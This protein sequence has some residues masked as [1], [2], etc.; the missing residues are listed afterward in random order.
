MQIKFN[1][2]G[3]LLTLPIRQLQQCLI[4]WVCMCAPLT[5]LLGQQRHIPAA[6]PSGL[7]VYHANEI[8]LKSNLPLLLVNGAV[9]T[10]IPS[11]DEKT[12]RFQVSEIRAALPYLKGA[13]MP[14]AEPLSRVYYLRY[15]GP[16]SPPEVAAAFARDP[17][18]AYA[19]PRYHF[20]PTVAPN[21]SAYGSMP[22]F[23][24]I[25]A[26]VAWEFAKGENGNVV[27]AIIDGGTDWNHED[28]LANVWTNPGEIPG[29]GIDD[30]GNGYVDDLHGWNF[31]TNSPDP[32]GQASTPNIARHGTHVAGTAAAV[33]NNATGMT[34]LSWNCKFMA[35]NIANPNVDDLWSY[36]FEGIVYAA[37]N[38]A[39]V[40]SVSGG[41]PFYTEF[42]REVVEFA[43]ANGALVVAAAG[44]DDQN[45]DLAPFYP[46][47]YDHVLSVGAVTGGDDV[48]AGFSNYGLSVDVFAPGTAIFSTTPGDTYQFLQGTSM[49]TPMVAALAGLV[50]TFRPAWS[51]DQVAE[52]IRV[53]CDDIRGFNPG[54]AG[55]IGK[56][57]INAIRALLQPSPSVRIREASF[58]ESGNDGIIHAGDTVMITLDL[59]NYLEN[60]ANLSL[61]LRP[62]DANIGFLQASAA[63]PLLNTGQSTTVQFEV[64]IDPGLAAGYRLPFVLDITDGNTYIDADFFAFEA[65]PIAVRTHN[66]P[67]IQASITNEGNIGWLDTLGTPGV[68]FVYEG[69]NLLFEAGILLAAGAGRISDCVRSDDPA[70]QEQDFQALSPLIIT[71]TGVSGF[72]EEGNVSLSD[73][74]AALPTGLSVDMLSLVGF[75]LFPGLEEGMILTYVLFNP[76]P[77]PID[78]IYLGLYADFDLNPDRRDFARVDGARKMASIQN[79][80]LNPSQL[81]AVKLLNPEIP[82]SAQLI[83]KAALVDDGFS[84]TEKW[85]ALRGAGPVLPLDDRDVSF[86]VAAGP[87]SLD[88]LQSDTVGFVMMGAK[89]TGALQSQAATYLF[90][91]N[92]FNPA[93]RLADDLSIR[94]LRIDDVFP[95]PF[96]ST[97]TLRYELDTPMQVSIQVCNMTGQKVRDLLHERQAPGSYAIEWNGADKGGRPL[98]AGTYLLLL[99]T[100]SGI[101]G[102]RVVL[103]R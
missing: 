43:H 80:S 62:G 63:I 17:H 97:T 47:N 85:T 58:T 68:G 83:D 103:F 86:V 98:P 78:S 2:Y 72:A 70:V 50:K 88:P 32:T 71:A 91:W 49:A 56:G 14:G 8:V 84:K 53:S 1:F 52:Q 87:L 67:R 15:E 92:L 26:E 94:G 66:T 102:Q 19:E 39:D 21:D 22:E 45:I 90:L 13:N 12:S 100:D 65:M 37:A 5:P 42:G 89:S 4:A 48:K 59:I 30:D 64:V 54:I 33:T 25:Q 95:N 44:N 82:F 99:R 96:S 28:L 46:A 6:M 9:A 60:A 38:G 24:R 73:A 79:A 34:S 18:V 20:F 10:G 57:R 93:T 69:N 77:A 55:Q 16:A 29:N 23:G 41:S 76:G 3:L 74:G 27:I 35:L 51:P 36:F 61:A 40:I 81:A 11:L 7:P 31:V 101:T 75:S